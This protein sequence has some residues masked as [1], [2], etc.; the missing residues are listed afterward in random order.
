MKTMSERD[1]TPEKLLLRDYIDHRFSLGEILLPSVVVLLALSFLNTVL[2]GATLI[3]TGLMYLFI[4]AVIVDAVLMW[5]GFKK[6]LAH[7]YPRAKTTGLL[8]Y[9]LNR[10]IQIRRFRMPA[11][12]IK[13]GE[14]F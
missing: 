7:R 8:F 4:L 11:P 9:G 3:T 1:S 10:M 14:D 13:R 6:E 12:R 2:P 5:R